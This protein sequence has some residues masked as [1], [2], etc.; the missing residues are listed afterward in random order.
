MKIIT[1]LTP[2]TPLLFAALVATVIRK[3]CS[4]PMPNSR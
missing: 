4:S 3:S 2:L 1:P